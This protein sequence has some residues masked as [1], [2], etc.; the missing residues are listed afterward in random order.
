M[1]RL[2]LVALAAVALGAGWLAFRHGSSSA[3]SAVVERVID[4]DT[5]VLADGGH[6]RLVQ[7]DTPEAGEEC[8]AEQA[9]ALTRRLL[10][11]GTR[12]RIELDPRLDH[13]DRYGRRLAYVFEEGENVNLELVRDG[14]ATPYFFGGRRGRYA[15]KLLA[16]A[17][18]ARGADR[19]LWAACPGTRLQPDESLS[20]GPS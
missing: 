19:G 20:T 1:G 10:P 13:V 5:I 3:K 9:T 15:S 6:V 18:S 17:Q 4:G 7:I 12:V 11:S 2:A 14:A 16:A 8:Y